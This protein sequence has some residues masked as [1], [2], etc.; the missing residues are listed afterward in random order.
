VSLLSFG[1]PNI[2]FGRAHPSSFYSNP[3]PLS[4]R[5]LIEYVDK[6]PF[7]GDPDS[8]IKICDEFVV[9]DAKSPASDDLSNLSHVYQNVN[10]IGKEAHQGRECLERHFLSDP[11]EHSR[12]V[13]SVFVQHF[14]L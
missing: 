13:E 6:V 5:Y 4:Q 14:R 1:S 8:T 11:F 9:F 10:R 12:R 2:S 3:R 7:K